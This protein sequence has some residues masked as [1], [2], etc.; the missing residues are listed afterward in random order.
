MERPTSGRYGIT[1]L[2][3]L[4][5]RE[6]MIRIDAQ[7]VVKY[8]RETRRPQD[9]HIALISQVGRQIRILRGYKLKSVFAPQAGVR[10]D[11]L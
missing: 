4:T 10:Y 5:G 9:M 2:P 8:V 3:L 6:E 7:H 1:A 11:G